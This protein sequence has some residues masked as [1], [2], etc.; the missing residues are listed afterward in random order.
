MLGGGGGK[1]VTRGGGGGGG[2]DRDH[3]PRSLTYLFDLYFNP[4]DQ[5]HT[6]P[7]IEG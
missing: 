5:L 7:V 1:A 3:T 4:S 2:G 6:L